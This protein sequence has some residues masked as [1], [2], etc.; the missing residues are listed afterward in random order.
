MIK[1]TTS[2]GL[3]KTKRIREKPSTLGL[4]I[5]SK[6]LAVQITTNWKIL[7]QMG[8]PDRLTC[9][10]RNL[11]AGQELTIRTRFRNIEKWTG[12]KL[13]KEWIKAVYCHPAYLLH[14]Q[15]TIRKM[16]GWMQD[17]L[18][19]R[20]LGEIS[21]ISDMQM[22][23]P[24]WQKVMKVKEENEKAGLQFHILKLRSRHLVPSLLGK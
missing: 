16:P 10:L 20:F 22:R 18:G 2:I 3:S 23:P 17:K 7:Q 19:S 24:L 14:K 13:G 21:I 15:N 9:L 8:I 1:L 12:S 4:L 6:P 11:F 5:T